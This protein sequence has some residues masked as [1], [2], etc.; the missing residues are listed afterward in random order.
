[1]ETSLVWLDSLVGELCKQVLKLPKWFCNT[2]ARI[3]MVLPS[4]RAHC[5]VR[6]LCFLR[7][8]TDGVVESTSL[9]GTRMLWAFGSDQ[10]STLLVREC[11]ELEEWYGT[12]LTE[13]L[14]SNDA[15]HPGA[16]EIKETI[17]GCD[18]GML[19]DECEGRSDAVLVVRI[20]R[21]MCWCKLWDCGRDWGPKC[22]A[23]LRKLV[24][25]LTYPAHAK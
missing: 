19:L 25:I 11:S 23:R 18:K 20:E 21:E 13:A 12:S 14:C 3:A 5:L 17:H 15:D 22:I 2:P 10:E 6:K 4:M 16:S 9:L 7:K 8:L 1:M 24:W